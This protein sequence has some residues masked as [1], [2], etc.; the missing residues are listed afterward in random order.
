MMFSTLHEGVHFT[1]G[2]NMT[3]TFATSITYTVAINIYHLLRTTCF[4]GIIIL[5]SP[6]IVIN[7]VDLILYLIRL[8]KYM[9]LIIIF[10]VL[11]T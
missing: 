3:Q 10:K 4:L 5:L 1:Y 7:S 2:N 8:I 11:K 6:F 9:V